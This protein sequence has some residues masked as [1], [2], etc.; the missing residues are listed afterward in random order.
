MFENK[1]ILDVY[2][3]R[4]IASWLKVGGSLRYRDDVDDFCEWLSSIGLGEE[5]VRRVKNIATNGKLEL[6]TS[7]K[8]FLKEKQLK[9]EIES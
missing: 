2:A 6:Q 4:F 9:M 8:K 5:E 1:V 7:A 3:T